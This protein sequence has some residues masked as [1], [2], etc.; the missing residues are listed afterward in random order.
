MSSLPSVL[1]FSS[2]ANVLIAG[3]STTTTKTSTVNIESEKNTIESVSFDFESLQ[4]NKFYRNGKIGNTVCSTDLGMP[5]L[6]MGGLIFISNHFLL[7]PQ[8]PLKK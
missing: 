6:L 3:Q 5:N 1:I 2:L 4:T 7:L 8:L